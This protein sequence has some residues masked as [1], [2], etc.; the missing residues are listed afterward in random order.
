MSTTERSRYATTM[1]TPV[2]ILR[3]HWGYDSFRPLQ[4]EI[5]NSVL[6]GNDTMGLMP[7]GGG[8]SITFQVPALVLPGLTLVITP[9][10][11]LMKDQ[12]DNLAAAGIRATAL[13]SGLSRREHR[14]GVDRCRLG[15]VKLL[16]VSPE[17]LRSESFI[18]DLRTFNVSLIVVDEAHCISQW[19]YDFRPSYLKI[20]EVRRLLPGVPVLALT[21][22]AT[23]RVVDDIMSVLKF[24]TRNLFTKSFARPNISYLVRHT[25]CKEQLL[26]KVLRSTAGTAIVYVRSRRRTREIAEM[27]NLEG[28]SADYYHAGLSPEEKNEKQNLWKTDRT[29]VIVATNAFGMG[30]DKPDVRVVVHIDPPGSLEEYYQEAGRAGRDGLASFAVLLVAKTDKALLTRRIGEAFPPKDYIVKVYEHVACFLGVAIGDGY[31]K[32][33]DFN[34]NLFCQRFELNPTVARN[35]LLLLTRAGYLEYVEE[36]ASR[37]RVMMLADKHELYDLRVDPV[38][39]RV[40]QLLLRSYTGLFADYVDI[41]ESQMAFRL[42]ISEENIYQSMLTLTRAHALHYIP[43]RTTP[44]ILYTTSREDNRYIQMPLSVYEEQ[45]ERMTDR[46]EAMKKFAFGTDKCR[47]GVILDY[48]GETARDCGNCDVCRARRSPAKNVDMRDVR[49]SILYLASQPGGHTI[50]YVASTIG[51][52]R[53][54]VIQMTRQLAEEEAIKLTGMKISK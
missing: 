20:V 25:D 46:I 42:G 50:D 39:D 18:A 17:K 12:V 48:F 37:S 47:A 29:R 26:L 14:L 19:G 28:I 7:T 43:R 31:N 8:K 24:R 34:F 45:R 49:Q 53:Y 51:A 40:L 1:A 4:E 2:E 16:Y 38:S 6:S 9:L 23:P 21:A 27:L 54:A 3:K 33:Y 32:V 22:S 52:P 35:A 11:S 36:T 5:I 44:C 10:I 15:K 30:I 13:H 41:N